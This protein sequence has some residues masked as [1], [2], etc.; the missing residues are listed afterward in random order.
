MVC[1][2]YQDY[3]RFTDFIFCQNQCLIPGPKSLSKWIGL[4]WRLHCSGGERSERAD[5]AHHAG[6]KGAAGDGGRGEGTAVQTGRCRAGNAPRR[7]VRE[8][9]C[10]LPPTPI[11]ML[12]L[13][14]KSRTVGDPAHVPTFL[15]LCR[16]VEVQYLDPDIP[17]KVKW[18]C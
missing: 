7:P 11:P 8:A 12:G 2:H 6:D 13:V 1:R 18:V 14:Y 10:E 3:I 15:G 5:A 16:A 4:W 9:G 17:L